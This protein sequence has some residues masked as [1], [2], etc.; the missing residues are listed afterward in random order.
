MT[1]PGGRGGRRSGRDVPARGRATAGAPA[2]GKVAPERTDAAEPGSLAETTSPAG[3]KGTGERK[4]AGR[5]GAADRVGEKSPRTPEQQRSAAER[6][7]KVRERRAA[8]RA[9]REDGADSDTG[10]AG[11]GG[12]RPAAR[13]ARPSA[14]TARYRRRR[15]VAGLVAAAVLLV[16]LA[17]AGW[18]ALGRFGPSVSEVRVTGNRAVT[19]ADVRAAADVEPG[20]PLASVDTAGVQARVSGIPGVATVEV[21]RSWPDALTVAVTERTPVAVVDAPGVRRLV[22]ATGLAYRSAPPEVPRLPLLTLPRVTPDDSATLA[23]VGLLTALP[24][25]VRD[26]VETVV[27]GPGGTTL[28]LTLTEGRRVLWGRWSPT[29][30]QASETARKAAILGPLLSR[31]GSVYDVS[32]PSL[33]TVRR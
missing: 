12:N 31:E 6:A 21:G 19:T 27:T 28:E 13:P 30:T 15:I 9:A 16:V 25:P 1:G 17:A 3:R 8:E 32:S 4:S 11:A 10:T 33:P 20:T 14:E 26:Q 24:V 2:D 29:D 23:A 5:A 22:D 7:R 18:W